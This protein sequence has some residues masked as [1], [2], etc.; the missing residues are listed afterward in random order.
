MASTRQASVPAS[1]PVRDLLALTRRPEGVSFAGG[2]P[3]PDLI[4]VPGL[5][6]SFAAVLAG[7]AGEGRLQYSTTEGD[8]DL[9]R[10]VT[11]IEARRGVDR[12]PDEVLITTGSQQ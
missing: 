9:R 6:D 1:S 4:D 12:D 5:R 8:P 11:A 2:L 3:A 7:D 10:E